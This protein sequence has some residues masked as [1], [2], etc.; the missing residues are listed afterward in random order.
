MTLF[1]LLGR[2]GQR[3]IPHRSDSAGRVALGRKK[4]GLSVDVAVLC[5]IVD[6]LF[7]QR[8][9]RALPRRQNNL[10]HLWLLIGAVDASEILKPT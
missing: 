6:N 1:C 4:P 9:G 2:F 7:G 5:E 8:L 3:C 10:R